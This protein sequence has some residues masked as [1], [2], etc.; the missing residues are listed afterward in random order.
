MIKTIKNVFVQG[1]FLSLL[2]SFCALARA[3]SLDDKYQLLLN[4]P[5]NLDNLYNYAQQ[6]IK[7]G[8]FEA[9]IAALESMLVIASNQPRVL[10]ELG[11]LYYRLGAQKIARTYINRSKAL[12]EG[13]NVNQFFSL[14]EFYGAAVDQASG[15][16]NFRGFV[17]LGLRT[18]SN[19]A[20]APEASEIY[21]RGKLYPDSREEKRDEN[22][23][24]LSQLF[25]R[26]ELKSGSAIIS[27]FTAYLTAYDENEQLD[28]A[29][30]EGTTG[31]EFNPSIG[32][33]KKFSIR[34]H[35]VLRATGQDGKHL[36]TALGGGIDLN[37][38]FSPTTN[39]YG[40]IQYRD[41]DFNDIGRVFDNS[42][43]SGSESRLDLRLSSEVT[44]GQVAAVRL[45]VRD[46]KAESAYL[47]FFQYQLGLRYTWLLENKLFSTN[48][49]MNIAPFVIR[50]MRDFDEVDENVHSL[51]TREDKEW[52]VGLRGLVPFTDTW[53]LAFSLEAI[54]V[55]SS[56]PNNTL[57]NELV[58]FS[59]RKDF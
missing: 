25:H 18:Q 43:R 30:I 57:E 19:P 49:K 34:P 28:L 39:F 50:R 9:A 53:S 35:F 46:T 44:H 6:A 15:E 23:F 11:T 5:S 26:Y 51:L 29:Y 24:F 55:N 32:K 27:D 7:E 52:R 10:L 2:F 16:D 33:A 42:Q 40:L 38:G 1:I 13:E 20:G 54:D 59:I 21:S 48:R 12:V 8:K 36:E 37:Y 31:I 14:T 56:L 47:G 45:L 4:D 41:L 22:L 17:A 3:D 58:S